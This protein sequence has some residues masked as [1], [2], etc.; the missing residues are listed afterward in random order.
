MTAQI[1]G[2]RLQYP[3]VKNSTLHVMK[4][5]GLARKTSSSEGSVVSACPCIIYAMLVAISTYSMSIMY[6][7]PTPPL[8]HQQNPRH[9][10]FTTG[11]IRLYFPS[12]IYLG[13]LCENDSDELST[14]STG[15]ADLEDITL[16]MYYASK[17]SC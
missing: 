2:E 11:P 6:I 13:Q 9:C 4:R 12:H 16:G 10:F 5:L 1:A 14:C 15:H 17:R 7:H 3:L 8:L